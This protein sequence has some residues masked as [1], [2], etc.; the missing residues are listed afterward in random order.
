MAMRIKHI[1]IFVFLFALYC[2]CFS[3]SI[4]SKSL[5][6][7]SL[8]NKPERVLIE[9]DNVNNRITI[10]SGSKGILCLNGYTDLIGAIKIIHKKFIFIQYKIRA[11]SGVK[12]GMTTMVCV[13]EGQLYKSLDIISM[14]R[15]EFKKTYDKRTDSLKSY[16]ES[17]IYSL[18]FSDLKVVK[19][20]YQLSLNQYQKIRSKQNKKEN[21]ERLDTLKFNFDRKN[22][23]F[24]TNHLALKGVY[25]I[26]GS[27]IE[28]RT[29]KG[30]IYPSIYL[31]NYKYVIIDNVWYN[32]L[33]GN[34]LVER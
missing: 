32:K 22:K 12:M 34:H 3:Q 1:S 20:N 18:K 28:Q 13:N 19:Q 21:C 10:K 11:G 7:N 8:T 16:N 31:K 30:E 26:E 9:L 4:E 14:E 23:V 25:K 27:K 17:G 29:F 2:N 24:Y 6:I 5:I 33:R 15:Y